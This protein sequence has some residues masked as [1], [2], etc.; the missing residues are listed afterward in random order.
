MTQEN[1]FIQLQKIIPDVSRETFCAL[2]R[3]EN[4]IQKWH[5]IIQLVS[6]KD[7]KKIWE[8]HIIN[9]LEFYFLTKEKKNIVDFGSG[10]GFPAIIIAILQKNRRKKQEKIFK[11]ETKEPNIY[12]IESNRKKAS[13]LQKIISDFNLSAKIYNFR[14]EESYSKIEKLDCI[15]ARALAPLEQLCAL[16]LPFFSKNEKLKLFFAKG[17][18]YQNEL[19]K[20]KTLWNFEVKIYQNFL[21]PK[22][23][24]LEIFHLKKI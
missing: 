22:S 13:F 11:E 19:E 18:N 9:S 3:Y 21:E 7:Q 6:D 14:I 23:V 8:R 15:T 1:K 17:E 4:E 16:S 5:K 2:L 12:M 24:I 20:I 10:G